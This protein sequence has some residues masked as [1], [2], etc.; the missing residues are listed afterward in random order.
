M[1]NI[2]LIIEYDGT[3]YCG[4]Q[5]QKYGVSVEETLEKVII[6]LVQEDIEI[7]GSSRTDSGVHARGQVAT[8]KTNS[9]ILARKFPLAINSKLPKDIV[10]VSSEEVN[11]DFH[12]RRSSKGKQYSYRIFNRRI[13]PALMRNSYAHIKYELD[14]DKMKAAARYFVGKHDFSSFKSKGGSGKGSVREIYN[15]NIIKD[16]DYITIIVEG[17]GFLYNMVRIIAGTLI[18]VGRGRIPYDSIEDII[19]SKNRQ[20]AGITAKAKGLYLEKVY[21]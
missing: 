8:F 2:K 10:V 15:L 13:D 19:N 3:N 9:R 7:I 6:D 21:Y 11:M 17:N 18:D 1:R 16:G 4:W 20:K 14:I 12:P 5:R